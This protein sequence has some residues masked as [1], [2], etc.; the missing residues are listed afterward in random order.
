MSGLNPKF[1]K[2]IS[3]FSK[4]Y[5][6]Y[7][8]KEPTMGDYISNGWLDVKDIPGLNFE[9]MGKIHASVLVSAAEEKKLKESK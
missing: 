1:E 8:N 4:V 9:E 7:F 5:K 6:D 3:G 2:Y